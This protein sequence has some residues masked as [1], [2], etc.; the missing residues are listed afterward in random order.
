MVTDVKA[1]SFREGIDLSRGKTVKRRGERDEI[2]GDFTTKSNFGNVP[3]DKVRVDP[4]YQRD[5]ATKRVTTMAHRWDQD[6]FGVPVVNLRSDG[7]YYLIDGQHRF[8]SLRLMKN[9]PSS[10]FCQVFVNLTIEQEAALFQQLDTA[11]RG[12]TAGAD[13]KARLVAGDRAAQEIVE[14]ARANGLTASYSSSGP[15]NLRA[16]TTLL[17]IHRRVGKHGLNR[18]FKVISQ[19]WTGDQYVG[20]SHILL[21]LETFF[22]HYPPREINDKHLIEVL[23]KESP[24]GLEAKGKNMSDSLSSVIS[25]GIARSIVGLYNKKMRSNRLAEW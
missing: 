20:S 25:T 13:F 14:A 3:L 21:G 16:F 8:E 12:L 2:L 17:A 1:V 24:A 9:P 11:R 18:I 10:I 7:Y 5:L 15:R 19:A 23:S 22:N 6:L 4:T